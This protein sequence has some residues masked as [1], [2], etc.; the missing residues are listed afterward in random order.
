MPMC[1]QMRRYIDE[2]Y[3]GTPYHMGAR[4]FTGFARDGEYAW[5]F[6]R[7]LAGSGVLGDLGT[8]WVDMAMY[9]LGPIASV[10]A[11]T[12]TMVPR[13]P[14]PDGSSY[15]ACDDVAM[16]TV[17][18]VSGATGQLLVSA[19][20]WEGTPFGQIHEFDVAGSGGTL[21]AMCDWDTVQQLRGSRAGQA[22]PP[23]DLP[24]SPDIWHGLRTDTIHNTYRDVFRTTEA[25]TRGW[26]T[27]IAEGGAVQPDIAHGVEVQRVI[28]AALVSAANDSR[29]ISIQ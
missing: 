25:M 11:T 1:V 28:D 23:S 7:E 27:A 26:V 8:H 18:F 21:H 29:M 4:Y 10:S 9:L 13:A 15:D 16:M 17:R 24:R 19:V 5:R 6:D 2:G 3:V 20:A 12:S 14:R 22:G